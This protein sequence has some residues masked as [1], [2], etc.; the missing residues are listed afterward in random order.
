M[1]NLV[2]PQFYNSEET[3]VKISPQIWRYRIRILYDGG[4]LN[5]YVISPKDLHKEGDYEATNWSLESPLWSDAHS[6]FTSVFYQ[7]TP[8]I[9]KEYANIW[10][11]PAYYT[12]PKKTYLLIWWELTS[13]GV[14]WHSI[15]SDANTISSISIMKYAWNGEETA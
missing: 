11:F 1:N 10:V 2:Q 14:Q 12:Q 6:L 3:E 9:Q 4:D 7:S 5:F 15:N 13:T 8:V